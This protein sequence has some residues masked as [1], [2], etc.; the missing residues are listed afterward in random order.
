MSHPRAKGQR[1]GLP[2]RSGPL[3]VFL[4]RNTLAERYNSVNS[5]VMQRRKIRRFLPWYFRSLIDHQD[6]GAHQRR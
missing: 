3:D 6:T 1:S 4:F 2:I 5:H